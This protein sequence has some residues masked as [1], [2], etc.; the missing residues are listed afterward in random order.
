MVYHYETEWKR[1]FIEFTDSLVMKKFWEQ[2][3]VKKV[4][5]TDFQDMKEPSNIDFLEKNWKCI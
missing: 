3:S 5:L 2:Q 4:I 1:Q